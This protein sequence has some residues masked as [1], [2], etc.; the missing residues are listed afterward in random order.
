MENSYLQRKQQ[1]FG[2]QV[3][4]EL[5][6]ESLSLFF[7]VESFGLKPDI[8]ILWS[9]HKP[10]SGAGVVISYSTL[11]LN[12]IRTGL[13][14]LAV[15]PYY[16]KPPFDF[17]YGRFQYEY[18]LHEALVTKGDHWKYEEEWGLT[19]ELKNTVGTGLY[20]HNKNSINLCPT[21]NEAMTEVYITERTPEDVVQ[22]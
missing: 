2:T 10:N 3:W 11:V 8:S 7:G 18:S 1:Q 21:P 19:L 22:K 9:S 12:K 20:D 13:G 4:N 17:G 6:R 5:L 16:F 15:V 14:R